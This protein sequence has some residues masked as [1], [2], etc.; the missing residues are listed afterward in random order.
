MN[1]N[2]LIELYGKNPTLQQ[3]YK[4]VSEN[5]DQP[6]PVTTNARNGM[7]VWLVSQRFL[8]QSIRER[9]ELR[10]LRESGEH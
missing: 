10:R 1:L 2:D 5:P 4:F 7:R 8:E 6:C 9:E 3:R